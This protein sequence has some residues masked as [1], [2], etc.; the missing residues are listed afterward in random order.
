M[1]KRWRHPTFA[2]FPTAGGGD[3]DF[4]F[5]LAHAYED[6]QA[7]GNAGQWTV[8]NQAYLARGDIMDGI[9]DCDESRVYVG[10]TIMDNLNQ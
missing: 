10:N 6:A 3:A 9:V 8:E 1:P 2:W 4:D 5:K 7:W